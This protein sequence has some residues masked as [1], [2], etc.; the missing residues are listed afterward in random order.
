MKTVSFSKILVISVG[1]AVILQQGAGAASV[2][3]NNAGFESDPV[4][5]NTGMQMVPDGWTLFADGGDTYV[6]NGSWLGT[7]AAGLGGD[8]YML[9][10]TSRGYAAIRQD[11][12]L[13]W[14]DLSPG[15]TMTIA[16]WTTYRAD[17]PGDASV[18]FWL[19]DSDGSGIYSSPMNATDGGATPAG[20]WTK[21]TWTY[22]VTQTA[23]DSALGEGWG[24]VNLQVGILNTSG[25][26][27][28]VMFDD[29][30]LDYTAVPEPSSAAALGALTVGL[31][32]RR[33][34]M[35]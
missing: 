12:A 1:L 8:Q 4:A 29:V 31:L 28:Q 5:A 24:A 9:V 26:N 16:A 6:G 21:R 2:V 10:H 3:I 14:S 11:V 34:R 27:Q 17:I 15:D 25:G 32:I 13:L 30:T 7:P 19:N 23:I 33:R 18:Y 22:T 35:A 20:T